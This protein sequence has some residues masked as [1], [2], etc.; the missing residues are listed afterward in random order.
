MKIIY[1]KCPECGYEKDNMPDFCP[2][3]GF[4]YRSYINDLEEKNRIEEEKRIKAQKELEEKQRKEREAR[5]T[6]SLK[7]LGYFRENNKIY[8]GLY[9]N[10]DNKDELI[11]WDILEEKDG[12]ALIIT[13]NIIDSIIYDKQHRDYEKSDI[14]SWL[15]NDFY[16]KAFNND[17]K[18]KIIMTTIGYEFHDH[19]E[20][21][22]EY[23]K[24][25]DNIFL[26]QTDE[27]KKYRDLLFES[28]RWDE[29]SWWLLKG[30]KD[31]YAISNSRDKDH[32]V[33]DSVWYNSEKYGVRPACWIN[34]SYKEKKTT[35]VAK[36]NKPSVEKA[37]KDAS[38]KASSTKTTTTAKVATKPTPVISAKSYERKDNKIYFGS[39]FKTN[40]KTKE[41][42]EWDILEEKNGMALIITHNVI[43]AAPFHATPHKKEVKKLFK[44]PN[45]IYYN[46][47]I[48]VE[49]ANNYV[50]S[51]IHKW[52]YKGFC[53]VAFNDLEKS[54][55]QLT[56][57][58]NSK[59]TTNCPND[60]YTCYN[61]NDTI[62]L[63]SYVEASKYLAN[64]KIGKANGTPY[65]K[66]KGYDENHAAW[67]LR[68]PNYT[69]GDVS[70]VVGNQLDFQYVGSTQVGV[71]PA[72]WIKL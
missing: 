17:Q 33:I 30:Y 23:K 63:L 66:S 51:S 60:E 31:Y 2:T 62:F 50:E 21:F 10:K 72:C 47:Y 65:A 29:S 13:H 18:E 5:L 46:S 67:W 40:D 32:R 39:F 64:G 24:V 35:T 6:K 8:F 61:T 42:I 20:I 15:N 11:E 7:D 53:D 36:A 19:H 45:T 25:E 49:Y 26:L 52:L 68:S 59:A 37:K 43:F 71:R 12:N 56:L 48:C 54:I 9:P 3:C 70:V 22:P 27:V 57:V 44:S 1:N 16:N 14:R 69:S 58:D 55:I 41:P 38:T 28:S 4:D 34:L